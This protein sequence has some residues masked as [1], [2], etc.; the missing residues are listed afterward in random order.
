[1]STTFIV[2]EIL[3][4]KKF[5]GYKFIADKKLPNPPP[6]PPILIGDADILFKPHICCGNLANG[7][8]C[9]KKGK[10]STDL[11][12]DKW[13]CGFHLSVDD[14]KFEYKKKHNPTVQQCSICFDDIDLK[15]DCTQTMCGHLF[16]TKCLKDWNK[17]NQNCPNCRTGLF[18]KDI[19][20]NNTLIYNMIL[21]KT[22]L[23][24]ENVFPEN[25]ETYYNFKLKQSIRMQ[26]ELDFL[27][28]CETKVI[29]DM[30]LNVVEA[31]NEN[32]EL[33]DNFGL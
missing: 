8:K 4:N 23:N 26:K 27:K 13:Y 31:I 11:K 7:D 16:H 24:I 20:V 30:A 17:M 15:D 9:Q 25:I 28:S 21:L 6:P 1:M 3:K 14:R 32:N 19:H 18:T 5:V 10:Y 12:T 33:L 2:S 29:A 22:A